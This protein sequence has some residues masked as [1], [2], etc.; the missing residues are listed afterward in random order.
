MTSGGPGPTAASRLRL[1]RWL[2]VGTR[3]DA[4]ALVLGLVGVLSLTACG[5]DDDGART[6]LAPVQPTA[7]VTIDAPTTTTS[8][9]PAPPPTVAG[10][11]VIV[12]GEQVYTVQPGDNLFGIAQQFGITLDELLAHNGIGID[13]LLTPGE[14][15][16]RI[17]AGSVAVEGATAQPGT[18]ATASTPTPDTT[19]ASGAGCVHVV[20]AGDFQGKV[21]QQYGVSLDELAAAN[22]DNPAWSV[23]RLGDEIVIPAGGSC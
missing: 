9:V 21:A 5:A 10:G 8:T 22:A 23:F 18:G 11:G 15:E 14:T 1:V 19:A 12:A 20:V 16:L 17:P 4:G 6:P 2:P 7:Y 13:E 3:S